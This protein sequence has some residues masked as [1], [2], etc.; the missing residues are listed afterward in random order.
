MTLGS[1]PA[2]GLPPLVLPSDPVAARVVHDNA[3][4]PERHTAKH[5]DVDSHRMRKKPA[6]TTTA[7]MA[8]EPTMPSATS[9][10]RD[11]QAERQPLPVATATSTSSSASPTATTPMVSH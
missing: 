11:H 1:S 2:M 9:A 8:N 6:A 10:R 7:A 3:Y 4:L 5:H